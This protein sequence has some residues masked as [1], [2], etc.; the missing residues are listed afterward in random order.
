MGGKSHGVGQRVHRFLAERGRSGACLIVVVFWNL[1]ETGET[2]RFCVINYIDPIRD[3]VHLRLRLW[4]DSAGDG[5][6]GAIFFCISRTGR[7]AGKAAASAPV[8]MRNSTVRVLLV[9]AQT[10][11]HVGGL[12][13]HFQL[14]ERQLGRSAA[15]FGVITGGDIHHGLAQAL[16]LG[17]SRLAGTDV[18]RRNSLEA[19]VQ[20]LS[21]KLQSMLRGGEI[22]DL[23]HC[24]DPLAT[25]AAITA[26]ARAAISIPVI[27]TV[28][29]PASREALMAGAVPGGAHVSFIRLLEQLA[30]AAT[31]HII[32][33]DRGQAEILAVDFNVPPEKITVVP[34]GIDTAAIAGLSETSSPA[35]IRQPY[36]VAP[37]RLVKKNGIEVALRATARLQSPAVLAVAGDGPLRPE[38]ERIAASLNVSHR[39]RF[40]GNLP[41]AA[42]MPLMRRA[43][44][45]V[46]PSVPVNGVVEAT[47]LAALEAMACGTP[48]LVS[49]IGGLREIVS[50]SAVG[51]AFPAGDEV[52]LASAMGALEA[53]PAGELAILRRRTSCAATA[54]DVNHWLSEIHAVYGK[55]LSAIEPK[56]LT[57]YSH[58]FNERS[59]H[60]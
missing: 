25:V 48:I 42:L 41:H 44:G 49:D 6:R 1:L 8:S 40:L 50:Q 53:T 45:V 14:L 18:T 31:A 29:G 24:H 55:T 54:F 35:D 2:C 36:F 10:I 27:Q 30:F 33:V 56:R 28:H 11:P 3:S 20:C 21:E 46:I 13:T 57:T 37:R 38:L 26:S 51:F 39:V 58:H 12:S 16:R 52:A 15:L 7:T 47:S 34:N 23:I 5:I 4:N 19:S 17:I 60:V 59:L 32:A 22:P 9:S 43:L